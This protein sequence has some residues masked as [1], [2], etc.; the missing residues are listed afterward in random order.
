MYLQSLFRAVFAAG[1][2]LPAVS[3][4]F[5]RL[6]Q[7]QINVD[8]KIKETFTIEL[9]LLGPSRSNT[10]LL[11]TTSCLLK[12]LFLYLLVSKTDS[13]QKRIA[14]NSDYALIRRALTVYY[15][16]RMNIHVQKF[17]SA[18]VHFSISQNRLAITMQIS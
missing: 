5:A 2:I 1:N 4:L 14:F 7:T 15:G 13:E 10:I 17:L 9:K 12:L 16:K 8:L 6:S 18:A 3:C 11:T